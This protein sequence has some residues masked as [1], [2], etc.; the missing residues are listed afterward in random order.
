[1]LDAKTS[2][3]SGR[4]FSADIPTIWLSDNDDVEISDLLRTTRED[5]A[6]WFRAVADYL[7][8]GDQ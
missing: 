7:D 2:F 1:M 8:G 3:G 6:R 5:A 4:M